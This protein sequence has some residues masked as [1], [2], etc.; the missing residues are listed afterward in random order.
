MLPVVRFLTNTVPGAS[1]QV[2][3]YSLSIGAG[4]GGNSTLIGASA[5]LVTAG[6]A[7]RAGYRITYIDFIKIGM[8]SMIL[9]VAMG[10]VWLLIRF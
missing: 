2:V 4:M 9:T 10:V 7:E 1:S 3:Y 5:N 8:P 6:I